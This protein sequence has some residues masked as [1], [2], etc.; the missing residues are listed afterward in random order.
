MRLGREQIGQQTTVIV[1]VKSIRGAS[2]KCDD[3]RRT[4]LTGPG[5]QCH[6]VRN[7]RL[8]MERETWPE[9]GESEWVVCHVALAGKSP[10]VQMQDGKATSRVFCVCKCTILEAPLATHPY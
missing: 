5:T 4:I 7:W 10:E 8:M 2:R 9:K 6:L 3:P 1:R